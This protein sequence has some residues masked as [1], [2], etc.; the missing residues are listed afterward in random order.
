MAIGQQLFLV[1]LLLLNPVFSSCPSGSYLAL[2]ECCIKC[3]PGFY[4]N[5]TNSSQ[6]HACEP[7][8]Y[9]SADDENT[10]CVACKP[11]TYSGTPG[12]YSCQDCS[13]GYYQSDYG[14]SNC[15]PCSV[16]TYT[17][18]STDSNKTICSPCPY[19]TDTRS[20]TGASQC[21]P[22]LLTHCAQCSKGFYL[23]N[24]TCTQ[25]PNGTT[26]DPEN[27]ILECEL[28]CSTLIECFLPD[29]DDLSGNSVFA[30][31][32]PPP[33]LALVE[34]TAL[35]PLGWTML[36]LF[37]VALIVVIVLSCVLILERQKKLKKEKEKL[38]VDIEEKYD[39]SWIKGRFA[40]LDSLRSRRL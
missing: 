21:L 27:E 6:C 22:C 1:F 31:E 30:M 3:S 24:Y 38:G 9:T 23:L 35:T 2:E 32:T 25:C 33:Q 34:P 39:Y 4:S 13:D 26:N 11:G 14:K 18:N 19:G 8:F 10:K 28:N 7:G 36:A 40:G 29:I 37:I 12:S 15:D 5:H 17:N 16:N 20:M